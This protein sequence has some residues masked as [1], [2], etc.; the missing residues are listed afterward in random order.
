MLKEQCD[1]SSMGLSSERTLALVIPK[2]KKNKRE[3]SCSDDD[4]ENGKPMYPS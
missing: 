3:R 4:G 1:P 2:E